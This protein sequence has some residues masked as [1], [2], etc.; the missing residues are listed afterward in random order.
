M[1]RQADV[2]AAGVILWELL[3]GRQLF[4][5]DDARTV[6]LQV[7]RGE[8]PLP[9]QLVPS[10]P[11]ELDEVVLTATHRDLGKRFLTARE[12]AAALAPWA[13]AEPD[14]V[15]V[16]VRGLAAER[17][18]ER[19][20]MLQSAV[21]PSDGRP[22]DELMAELDPP[23][24]RVA[25]RDLPGAP[26][27]RARPTRP[28]WAAA[29]GRGGDGRGAHRRRHVLRRATE[30][31]PDRV[32]R[33][34]RPGGHR[35]HRARRAR[36]HARSRDGDRERAG[37]P[38]SEAA[39]RRATGRVRGQRNGRRNRA[40]GDRRRSDGERRRS[41]QR[42]RELGRGDE[43]SPSSWTRPRSENGAHGDAQATPDAFGYGGPWSVR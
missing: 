11:P 43:A 36:G 6:C 1:T 10:L 27:L 22:I 20:R 8:I 31:R 40:W 9:S 23:T 38:P 12:F 18:A 26:R 30:P 16:W 5:S 24:L 2:Y 41:R 15:G 32:G 19:L 21:T 29:R 7:L 33:R 39:G 42:G 37:L 28:P 17:L 35:S 14:E 3:A 13:H 34:A 4:A 25:L